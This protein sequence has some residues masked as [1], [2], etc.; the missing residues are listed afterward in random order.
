MTAPFPPYDPASD[1]AR[2]YVDPAEW[3]AVVAA[4]GAGGFVNALDELAKRSGDCTPPS[5]LAAGAALLRLLTDV[6]LAPGDG[7]P[8]AADAWRVEPYALQGVAR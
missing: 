4:W 2:C 8:D 3:R 6:G 1:L 5:V 7:T